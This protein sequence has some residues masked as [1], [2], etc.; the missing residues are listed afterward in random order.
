MGGVIGGSRHLPGM[1]F[2]T[3]SSCEYVIDCPL[4]VQ[5]VFLICFSL[6]SPASFENVRAKVPIYLSSLSQ[7][8]TVELIKTQTLTQTMFDFF[9]TATTPHVLV[10]CN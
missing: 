7:S 2:L 4:S 3:L 1:P 6:V 5:D 10:C 9:N 8:L